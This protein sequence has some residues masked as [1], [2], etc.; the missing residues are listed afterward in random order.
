MS[1]RILGLDTTPFR[2]LFHLH[3]DALAAHGA[4]RYTVDAQPGFPDRVTLT[5]LPKGAKVLLVNHTHQPAPTP[6]RASHA[7][8]VADDAE[9]KP[10]VL[11][12]VPPMLASRLI[13]LRA[14]DAQHMMVDAD[15]MDGATLDEGIARFFANPAVDY[16]HAHFAKRGCFAARID[17]A[18]G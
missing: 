18:H 6:Y 12:T 8:F 16:L 3:D 14:F 10:A 15:V 11:H 2:P 9:A 1:F 13:S 7:I 5:D 17:R 4:R